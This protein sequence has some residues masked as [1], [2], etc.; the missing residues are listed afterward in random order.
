MFDTIILV[1]PMRGQEY[2]TVI[3]MHVENPTPFKCISGHDFSD[4][5]A[6][7]FLKQRRPSVKVKTATMLKYA[8]NASL[9]E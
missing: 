4:L 5:T 7:Y 2:H 3:K 6:T 1:F 8:A 9:L